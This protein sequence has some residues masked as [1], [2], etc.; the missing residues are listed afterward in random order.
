MSKAVEDKEQ[1]SLAARAWELVKMDHEPAFEACAIEFQTEKTHAADRIKATGVASDDNVFEQTVL[2]LDE[3]DKL[4]KPASTPSSKLAESKIA[5]YKRASDASKEVK[6]QAEK[7]EKLI[8]A[9]AGESP[10]KVKPK[11]DKK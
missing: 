5:S 6:E 8:A 10:D 2:E 3:Q 4:A 11:E 7:D 9:A 1:G